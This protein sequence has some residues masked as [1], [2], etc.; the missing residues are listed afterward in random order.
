[1][2]SKQF[3]D[4]MNRIV[5]INYPPKRIISLVP[6]Q[7][8]LLFDLGLAEEVIGITKFCIH[9]HD[10]FKSTTKIGGTKTLNF[11]QIKELSPDLI[12]GNKEENEQNQMEELMRLFPVWMSDIKTLDDSLQMIGMVGELVGRNEE[13]QKL[14]SEIK[15]GFQQLSELTTK[16][17]RNPSVAYFIW[18]DP[19]M[20]AGDETFIN[21]MLNRCGMKNIFS[22][23]GRYPETSLE[24]LQH[25][26]PELVLLSSE[27]YPFKDKHVAE[28]RNLIPSA[29][30]LLVDGEYFSWYGSR[31]KGAP[32]YFKNI[33]TF[34]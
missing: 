32:K 30:I 16:M 10:K 31:I 5:E 3:T 25:L 14:Q 19:Y 23:R 27:P 4:Q 34:F 8:E 17:E 9:P 15:A 22:G 18:K 1:M 33:F 12:I 26:S 7:T 24:E 21:D 20:A 2:H 29:Q 28:M 11:E 13:A 6:S